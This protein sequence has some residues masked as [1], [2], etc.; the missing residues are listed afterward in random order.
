[1][2]IVY[3]GWVSGAN[4]QALEG[5]SSPASEKRASPHRRCLLVGL[6]APPVRLLR[7]ARVHP[8]QR[9]KSAQLVAAHAQLLLE[10]K[11]AH[12]LGAGRHGQRAHVGPI[13]AVGGQQ[14]A[15]DPP[16]P[17]LLRSPRSSWADVSTARPARRSGCPHPQPA[18]PRPRPT[19][20]RRF[21]AP[22]APPCRSACPLPVSRQDGGSGTAPGHSARRRP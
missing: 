4:R 17:Q 5:D 19:C 20:R 7:R 10:D 15:R 12:A 1:M 18:A 9:R 14:A 3:R 11:P 13:A 21:C 16:Y 22:G 6:D 8:E 2:A